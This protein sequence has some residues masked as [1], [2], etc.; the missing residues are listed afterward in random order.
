MP[1]N[2]N[3]RLMTWKKSKT[4]ESKITF[5]IAWDIDPE[6]KSGYCLRRIKCGDAEDIP[7]PLYMAILKAMLQVE[8]IL[9]GE[10]QQP[11]VLVPHPGLPITSPG[12]S[13]EEMG[14]TSEDIIKK[15]IEDQ[16]SVSPPHSP[17]TVVTTNKMRKAYTEE[18][19]NEIAQLYQ[20]GLHVN[21][22]ARRI[23][24]KPE[25]IYK[26][27]SAMGVKRNQKREYEKPEVIA[28]SDASDQPK[29][30]RECTLKKPWYLQPQTPN[31]RT[32]A[33]HE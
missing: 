31:N 15:Y 28:A 14:A 7:V 29:A 33:K 18:E 32:K 24:R 10:D 12:E 6:E 2:G 8:D 21:E 17:K 23:G 26:L 5:K 19:K 4:M 20:D 11:G 13:L 22:I 3:T 9:N 25:S 1:A 30:K 27:V 16:P